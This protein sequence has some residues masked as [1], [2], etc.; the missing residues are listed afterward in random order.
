MN[1][2]RNTQNNSIFHYLHFDYRYYSHNMIIRCN[3]YLYSILY[4]IKTKDMPNYL[5]DLSSKLEDIC[6]YMYIY[7]SYEIRTGYFDRSLDVIEECSL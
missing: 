5:S 2:L 4:Y 1:I 6:E 3:I 7:T